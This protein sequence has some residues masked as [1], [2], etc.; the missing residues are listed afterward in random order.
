MNAHFFV[1]I[2][3]E[4]FIYI[5]EGFSVAFVCFCASVRCALMGKIV[6]AQYHILG[7]SCYG[8]SVFGGKYIVHTQH[9]EPGFRLSL[10]GKRH[11]YSHLIPV[12]VRI[13]CSTNQRMELYCFSFHQYRFKSLY[14][15]SVKCRCTV[16]HNGMF[17]YYIF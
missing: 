3:H 17:L 14:P 12:K 5:R 6:T 4:H 11:M 8:R 7:G 15:K 16:Q 10:H 9:Q 13:E 2:S 1:F